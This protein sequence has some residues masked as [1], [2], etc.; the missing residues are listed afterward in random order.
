MR[1]PA[2]KNP[3]CTKLLTWI[4]YHFPFLQLLRERSPGVCGAGRGESR[5]DERV[6]TFAKRLQ[7]MP[8]KELFGGVAVEEDLRNL[9]MSCEEG[10]EVVRL[11]TGGVD[12]VVHASRSFTRFKHIP[13]GDAVL[14]ENSFSLRI[15]QIQSGI[16]QFAHNPPEGVLRMTVELLPRE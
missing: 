10:Y 16:E 4:R 14:Y 15:G 9:A 3:Y 7:N 5:K 12:V 11:D 8:P 6:G 1:I 2:C 13:N